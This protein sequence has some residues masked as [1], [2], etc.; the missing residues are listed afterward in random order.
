MTTCDQIILC[1]CMLVEDEWFLLN[2][3]SLLCLR[4]NR[5]AFSYL[6]ILIGRPLSG[7][8]FYSVEDRILCEGCYVNTLEKC[9][10]CK[11]PVTEKIL[12]ATG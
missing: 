3:I 4:F 5:S 6:N 2:I 9:D 10:D 12:R 11:L 7:H 8:S 1:L